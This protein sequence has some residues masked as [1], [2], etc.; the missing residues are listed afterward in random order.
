MSGERKGARPDLNLA[1][2]S[3]TS[4]AQVRIASIWLHRDRPSASFSKPYRDA[5]GIAAIRLTNGQEI[6]VD[7]VF[8]NAY[9]E[10]DQGRRETTDAR[11][12]R[13]AERSTPPQA[14]LDVD[15]DYSDDIPF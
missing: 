3:K 4:G 7:D 11:V 5:P 8:L 10:R 13:G 2:K 1:I 9:D 6:R 12:G 14:S 15:P